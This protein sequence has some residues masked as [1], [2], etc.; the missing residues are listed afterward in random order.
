M[1]SSSDSAKE[2]QLMI[3]LWFTSGTRTSPAIAGRA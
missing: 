3:I 2:R 1:P